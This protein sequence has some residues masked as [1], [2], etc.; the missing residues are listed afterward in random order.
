MEKLRWGSFNYEDFFNISV[1]LI[2]GSGIN[3]GNVVVVSLA[4]CR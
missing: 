3:Y 4:Q 2:N 1:E